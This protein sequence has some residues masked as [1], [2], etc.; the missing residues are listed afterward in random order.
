MINAA[1]N[2]SLRRVA[3]DST[4][5]NRQVIRPFIE[6]HRGCNKEEPENTILAFKRAIDY[7]CDAIECDVWLTKD[8]IPVVIH[9]TQEGE[10]SET[11]NGAGIINELTYAELSQLKTTSKNLS[12][13]TL[14]EVLHLCKDKIFINI[15]MKDTQFSECFEK[16]LNLI[17]LNFMKNQVAISSFKHQYW[18]EMKKTNEIENIEFGFL[19]D[20]T[21][22]QKAEFVL[23]SERKNS[24]IN[25]W[26][27]EINPE[28]VEKAHSFDIAVQCWFCMDDIETDDIM[29]YLMKCGVDVIC[30]N[31]PEKAIQIREIVNRNLLI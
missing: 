20:T 22:D 24:T 5:K 3:F 17:N 29:H 10:I 13:P 16:V 28:F 9:C 14:Q 2:N 18:E 26:Y 19:Y 23:N 30:T 12:V 31:Y 27:K 21:D 4:K 7:K 11:I 1:N 15:E 6:C 25:V 8:K